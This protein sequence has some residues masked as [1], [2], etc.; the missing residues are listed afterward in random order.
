MQHTLACSKS[1]LDTYVHLA[2][3]EQIVR[4]AIVRCAQLG[5]S[6]QR[7]AE[8]MDTTTSVISR[9]ESGQHRTG[10]ETRRRLA[11]TLEGHAVLGFEFGTEGE[12]ERE[13]VA[14]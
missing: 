4:S 7:V 3:F 10:T 2:P 13:L 14:L 12:P 6:Q 5:L 9:I 8:H 11:E 1:Y